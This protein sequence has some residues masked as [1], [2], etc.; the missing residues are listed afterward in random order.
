MTLRMVH[1]QLDRFLANTTSRC[2]DNPQERHIVL[3]IVQQEKVSKNILDFL[4][5]I[6][7]Q[8]VNNLVRY[9]QVQHVKFQ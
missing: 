7:L 2:I 1:E 5:L 8:P 9:A 6:K 4:P 3:R